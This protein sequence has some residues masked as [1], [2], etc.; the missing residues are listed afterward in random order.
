M[1]K[2]NQVLIFPAVSGCLLWPWLV[3][4]PNALMQNEFRRSTRQPF[5]RAGI[6]AKTSTQDGYGRG[7]RPPRG[8]DG[9]VVLPAHGK[10]TQ[11]PR[12]PD[13]GGK[14]NP[15]ATFAKRWIAAS[16]KRTRAT[17]SFSPNIASETAPTMQ[18]K[19]GCPT[20]FLAAFERRDTNVRRKKLTEVFSA[21]LGRKYLSKTQSTQGGLFP[22]P[23]RWSHDF[24]RFRRP[25]IQIQR[26]MSGTRRNSRSPRGPHDAQAYLT[27]AL[28]SMKCNGEQKR[29]PI[30]RYR[31][32]LAFRFTTLKRLDRFRG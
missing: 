28:V 14:A 31:G 16:Q 6:P 7:R 8:H 25:V 2:K 24:Y 22:T 13:G 19:T 9:G 17:D 18:G 4:V 29:H 1:E 12:V 15:L 30:N 3:H 23:P 5:I 20:L 11:G 10:L 26:S 21:P 27:T 32:G